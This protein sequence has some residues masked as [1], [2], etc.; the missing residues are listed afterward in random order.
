MALSLIGAPTSAGAYGPG[1]ERTPSAFRAHGLVSHLTE[2]GVEV[3]DRGDGPLAEWRPDPEHPTAAN[4]DVVT[5]VA[6]ILAAAV[7]EALADGDDVL[8]LGGDCTIEIGTVAGAVRD[9]SRVGLA[10]VDLDTDLHTPL[11]GDGILDWMVVGHLLDLPG[12]H[13]PLAGLGVRRPLL[14]PAAL[15]YFAADS[16]SDAE[17]PALERLGLGRVGLDDVLRRPA[18]VA[19]QARTWA[20]SYDRLLVH[21]DVDVLAWDDFPIAENTRRRSGLTLESLTR[22]LIDLCALPN[23]R[24]LTLTEINPAHAPDQDDAFQRL[25]EMLGRALGGS[26]QGG[27]PRGRSGRPSDAGGP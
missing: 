12:A 23:W 24:G 10:Y 4:A 6:A 13:P 17:R 26:R 27:Q 14:D 11:T 7:A 25:V 15:R 3:R 5:A 21:V 16:I 19:A 8:V 1:Q 22:L 20:A 9:G 18:A 2:R